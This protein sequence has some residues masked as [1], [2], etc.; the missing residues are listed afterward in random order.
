MKP[1]ARDPQ[2]ARLDVLDEYGRENTHGAAEWG[3]DAVIRFA[4]DLLRVPFVSIS[5]NGKSSVPL[6]SMGPLGAITSIHAM[7]STNVMES[8]KS[9]VVADVSRHPSFST[10]TAVGIGAIKSYLGVPLISPGGYTIGTLWVA[11][12]RVRRF[13]LKHQT[14]LE[15]LTAQVIAILELRKTASALTQ[16]QKELT[17]HHSALVETK[18]NHRDFIAHFSHEVRNPLHAILGL[19]DLLREHELDVRSAHLL[20]N[21]CNS[22]QHMM[23]TLNA[24]LEHSKIESGQ[25]KLTPSFFDL[26][27]F[28]DETLSPFALLAARKGVTFESKLELPAHCL[29]FSDKVRLRQVLTNLLGNALKFTDQ[30]TIRFE[31]ECSETRGDEGLFS[32][33]IGD[34]GIGIDRS[35]QSL[36]FEPY[37]QVSGDS[38][39]GGSGLGLSI[40]R[41]IVE[42]MDGRI[43]LESALGLGSTFWFMVPLK[44]TRQVVTLQ[45]PSTVSAPLEGR[46]LLLE[47]N[48]LSSAMA[49]SAIEKA[50][51]EVLC[52]S[53][54]EECIYLLDTQ[55]F[56]LILMDLHLGSVL[57]AT[58]VHEVRTK[59]CSPIIAIS[60]SPVD[61]KKGL[62]FGIDDSLQKP[63]GR[64]ALIQKLEQWLMSPKEESLHTRDWAHSLARLEEQCGAHFLHTTIES[65]VVRHPGE[66]QKLQR[67]LEEGSWDKLELAAHSMKSTLATL[68]LMHLARLVTEIETIAS[69]QD[70]ALIESTLR[71]FRIDSRRMYHRLVTYVKMEFSSCEK[72]S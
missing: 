63:F 18:K 29:C 66:V 60:G 45:T 19:S 15:F 56:D 42:T 9:L 2:Q 22:S 13:S 4:A 50:G 65:F 57:P 69:T 55:Y 5:L 43:G 23:E 34:S 52:A 27:R 37:S 40:C 38:S 36:L 62:E 11:D 44:T 71:Q 59:S 35:N 26:R 48:S 72:A 58:L 1:K 41:K 61:P 17:K 46:I 30:G 8:G 54:L 21:L 10:E 12:T 68:G 39:K 16:T 64:D 25:I 67:Y 31:L 3:L 70:R 33:R 53:N 28:I 24:L 32:F 51:L 14:Q 47:D 49:V 20:Q 7:L 6:A